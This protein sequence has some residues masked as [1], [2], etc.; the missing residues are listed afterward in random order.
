MGRTRSYDEETVLS[1]AMHAFRR[2]G[3]EA[4]SIRDLEEATGL[5]GGSIYNSFGDKAGLFDAA[6]A[7]YNRVVLGGRIARYAPAEAGLGGLR[8]LFLSLLR[9]PN[10][11]AFGCLITNSA[12]EFGCEARPHRYVA[13]GLE[14]LRRAFAERLEAARRGGKL[15]SRLRPAQAALK[16][17]A[18][19]QGVLVLVRA[20]HDKSALERLIIEEFKDMEKIDDA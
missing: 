3:Y 12:V 9:E 6:F 13:E 4:A 16:L 7:H 19:Y 5:K 17:L 2:K 11:E 14:A 20:G 18:L 15:R 8:A 1:G 10:G